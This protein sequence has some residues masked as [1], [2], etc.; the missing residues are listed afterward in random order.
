MDGMCKSLKGNKYA[1]VK[2]NKDFFAVAYPLHSKVGAG[3]A[4]CQFVNEFWPTEKLTYDGSQE[5]NGPKTE[6]MANVRKHFI[7]QHTTEPYRPNHNFAEGVIRELRRKWCQVMVRK[8]VP[9]KLWVC[10][11]QNRT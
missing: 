4:L 8:I 7:D 6:F 9:Q 1:Q 3:D 11:V 5:Q 2:A 10:D